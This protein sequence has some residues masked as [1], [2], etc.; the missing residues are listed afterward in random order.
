MKRLSKFEIESL[1][2]VVVS[3]L[4]K[5]ESE[6]FEKECVEFVDEWNKELVELNNERKIWEDKFKE[7]KEKIRKEIKVKGW[8]GVD[9]NE[10]Y[11][12]NNFVRFNENNFVEWSVRNKIMD[13][14]II[15]NLKGNDIDS[16]IDSLINK[17]KS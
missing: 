2:N 1:V 9:V 14:I 16:L 12:D 15:N 17:F 11:C 4:E 7:K 13:E 5:I 8:K 3:K 10:W 6:K